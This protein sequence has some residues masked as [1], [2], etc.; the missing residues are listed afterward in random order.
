[1]KSYLFVVLLGATCFLWGR[2]EKES[3]VPTPTSAS[4]VGSGEIS[5]LQIA[6]ISSPLEDGNMFQ[7]QAAESLQLLSDLY[8]FQGD[9]YEIQSDVSED[10]LVLA[11]SLCQKE[12]DLLLGVGWQAADPFSDLK[13][14]F[15]NINFVVI[16][17]IA[18]NDK[19]KSIT[20]Q[21]KESA[22]ILGV[23]IA[24]AFPEET[25]FG[26]VGNY[27]NVTG[28]EY[29]YGFLKGL[30]WVNGENHLVY[31]YANSYHNEELAYE[32]AMELIGEG[33][34]VLM[35]AISSVANEGIFQAVLEESEKGNPV[36]ATGISVDQT[37]EENPYIISGL[38]KNTGLAVEKVLTDY[39]QEHFSSENI[40]LGVT[41]NGCSVVS[42][43]TIGENFLNEEVLTPQVIAVAHEAYRAVVH[44]EVDLS[45]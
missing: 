43:T 5:D 22:F 21:M 15:D 39:I 35:G 24:A 37:R 14:E 11:H 18:R 40:V 7:V 36:Y 29:R 23:L 6:M 1:M 38:T 41:E 9:F 25:Q 2:F 45:Y 13:E 33:V 16:D 31:S 20:F 28:A 26:F 3:N 19:V 4:I 12:Y 34:V 44:K 8:G 42:V 30:Q 27:N 17:D 10:W 32:C